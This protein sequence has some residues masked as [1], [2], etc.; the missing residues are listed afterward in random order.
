MTSRALALLAVLVALAGCGSQYRAPQGGY[1]RAA[2]RRAPA[3]VVPRDAA[4]LAAGNSLFA[5]RLLGLLAASNPTVALSPLS[6]TD[7]LAM[8]LPGARGPTATQIARALDFSLPAARLHAAFNALEQSLATVDVPGVTLSIANALYG[9]QGTQFRPAFLGLLARDYGAGMRTVDFQRA[10]ESARRAINAWVSARTDGKIANLLAPGD[11]DALT[12]L[13]LV[14][15]VY[16]NAKWDSPFD[17]QQTAPA[18]FRAPGGT[19]QVPTMHQQGTFAYRRGP[20]YQTLELPY[21]GGRLAFDILLPDPGRLPALVRRL[22]SGG[23]LQAVQGLVPA[24][25]QLALPK[26]LLRSSFQLAPPLTTLGMPL[27]FVA[28]GADFSGIAGRPGDLYVKKVI[29]EAYLRLDEAGT[30]AA[31][32][33]AVI[34]EGVSAQ[35]FRGISFTVDRPFAFVLRDRKTGAVLFLGTVSRP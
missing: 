35:V 24:S 5:G 11:V 9:Q 28:G 6:I 26:L 3:T 29:H 22:A 13:V 8:T 12:Q 14:N 15:A 2:D 20:G 17:R 7:A 16:L 23:P 1:V 32:A 27:A 34:L 19:V 30:Q 10:A 25:V 21:R 4:T 31:A 18:P 33:T